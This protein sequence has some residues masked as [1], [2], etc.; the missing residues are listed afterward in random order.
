V[1]EQSSPS[2]GGRDLY[3]VEP[4]E[5]LARNITV[6]VR[7]LAGAV[8]SFFGSF[9]FAYVY[10]RERD[11]AHVWRPAGVKVPTGTG[12]AVLACIV[13]AVAVTAAALVLL[14]RGNEGAW[15]LATALSQLLALAALA[16]QCYQWA[17]LDFG[18]GKGPYASVFVAWTG[19]YGG[20]ALTSAMYWTQTALS[21]SFRHRARDAD[22]AQVVAVSGMP[23]GEGALR[24]RLEA[25]A[26]SLTFFWCTIGAVEVVTFALLYLAK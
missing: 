11:S 23:G 5:V 12:V 1:A 18:P 16:I 2:A 25:E 9:L 6:G 19:F 17:V 26:Q 22:R 20:I 21:T 15:R 10:L 13:A 24:S 3:F 14:R 7:L 8:V 4:P